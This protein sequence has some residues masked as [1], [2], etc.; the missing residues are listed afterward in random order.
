MLLFAALVVAAV[1]RRGAWLRWTCIAA[2]V[3]I[4]AGPLRLDDPV[5]YQL[6]FAAL[7]DGHRIVCATDHDGDSV[8]VGCSSDRLARV[9]APT[10]GGRDDCRRCRAVCGSALAAWQACLGAGCGRR[11]ESDDAVEPGCR[12]PPEYRRASQRG[13]FA[14]DVTWRRNPCLTRKT[15]PRTTCRRSKRWTACTTTWIGLKINGTRRGAR[16][17]DDEAIDYGSRRSG[18]ILK[19]HQGE[20]ELLRTGAALPH[21]YY[22]RN[23]GQIDVATLLPDIQG[24]RGGA[25]TTRHPRTLEHH[26]GRLQI[27]AWPTLRRSTAWPAMP[28]AMYSW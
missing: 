19:A 25:T 12:R 18:C 7:A 20:I 22:D 3:A 24:M 21:Y 13:L 8:C 23:Y 14:G 6:E 17:N 5:D 26:A 11:V 4:L 2:N 16:P 1:S 9:P 10:R 28:A 15:P 27:R